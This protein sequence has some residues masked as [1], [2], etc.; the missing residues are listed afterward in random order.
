MSHCS[1][2]PVHRR[3]L[4]ELGSI[5]IEIASRGLQGCIGPRH[6]VSLLVVD[7][8]NSL[9]GMARTM[10]CDLCTRPHLAGARYLLLRSELQARQKREKKI[11]FEAH[12][13]DIQ[14]AINRSWRITPEA[15]AR[16]M[17][18]TNFRATIQTMWIQPRQDTDK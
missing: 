16:Y 18:I 4:C 9:H 8:P 6:R 15:I 2:S 14:E 5:S 17:D 11:I 10:V 1:C 3:H 12:I 7:Y 13:R